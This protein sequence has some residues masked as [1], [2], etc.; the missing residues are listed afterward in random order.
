VAIQEESIPHRVAR[1]WLPAAMA[2]GSGL[3]VIALLFLLWFGLQQKEIA[4][5]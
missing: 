4:G 1:P 5:A 2:A 3:I